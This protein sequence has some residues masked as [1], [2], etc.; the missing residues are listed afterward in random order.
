MLSGAK[1]PVKI[2]AL[3]VPQWVG[4]LLIGWRNLRDLGF[5]FSN[6]AEGRPEKVLLTRVGAACDILRENREEVLVARAIGHA[7]DH[8]IWV[9]EL[10]LLKQQRQRQREHGEVK[11]LL[12]RK[13]SPETPPVSINT[14]KLGTKELRIKRDRVNR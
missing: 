11:A 12:R 2:T 14:A 8:E 7:V 9:R 13:P 4:D 10:E 1:T 6:D 3:V 5:N